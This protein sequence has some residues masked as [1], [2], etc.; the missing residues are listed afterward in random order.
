MRIG[1]GWHV[2]KPV[3]WDSG[4][5][6]SFPSPTMDFLCDLKQVT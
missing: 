3:D 2:V 6:G 1:G 4:G 5:Q